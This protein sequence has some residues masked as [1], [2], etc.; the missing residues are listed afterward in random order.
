MPLVWTH[1]IDN[2]DW[3]ELSA[4]Y[5]AAPLGNKNPAD[6]KTV[7]MNSMF[8]CFVHDDGKLAGRWPMAW[9]APTSATSR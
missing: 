2:V 7:F 1:L 5:L 6:L 9:T 8:R 3:N 4:L